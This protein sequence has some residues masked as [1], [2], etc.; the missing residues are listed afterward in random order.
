MSSKRDD[1][2]DE[3]SSSWKTQDTPPFEDAEDLPGDAT[4]RA[5]VDL[6]RQ[7]WDEIEA[8]G[9]VSSH[10][11]KPF[12][13]HWRESAALIA[14]SILAAMTI[15]SFSTNGSA[16]LEDHEGRTISEITTTDKVEVAASGAI[17]TTVLEQ[18]G[19]L[20][21]NGRV[22]LILVQPIAMDEPAILENEK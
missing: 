11:R 1:L 20:L 16:K 10:D 12:V 18:G 13:R 21:K 7:A 14:A 3:L 5:V 8:P 2:F 17:T 4:T 6:L 15:W 19:L 22:R 9:F